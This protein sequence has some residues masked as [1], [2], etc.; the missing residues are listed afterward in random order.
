MGYDPRLVLAACAALL[1]LGC[2]QGPVGPPGPPGPPGDPAVFSFTVDFFLD[3]AQFN[4]PI[5]SVQYDAPEISPRV[6]QEGAVMAYF[7]EQGTWT[8]L[9]YTY[10]VESEN[11]AAVDR[12]V[13]LG[14]A[15][16][17]DFLEVFYEASRPEVLDLLPDQ[18]VKVVIIDSF[19]GARAAGVNLDDYAAVKSYYGL[20]NR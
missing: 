10:G 13:T 15:Y 12:T 8:A 3:E 6:V 7:R 14:F 16:E 11:V 17:V 5:A 2:D 18:E 19:A 4:G 9:P 1:F 20:D